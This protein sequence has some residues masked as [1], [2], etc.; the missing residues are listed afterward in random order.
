MSRA[1]SPIL[2]AVA[3]GA[4]LVSLSLPGTAEAQRRFAVHAESGSG[5]SIV[6]VGGQALLRRSPTYIEAGVVSWL[7]NDDGAWVGGG[8]RMEVEDRASVGG[9]VRSGFFLQAD[10]LELR[11][12]IGAVVF[13]AP[14][15]LVGAEVSALVSVSLGETFAI[16]LRVMADGFFAGDDL[17]PGT[18]LFMANATLGLEIRL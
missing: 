6:G 2:S 3:L 17:I 18:V 10:V 7:A 5:L 11:P 14:Y 12:S 1:P 13:I 4:A 8:V 9:V 16:T 15:T